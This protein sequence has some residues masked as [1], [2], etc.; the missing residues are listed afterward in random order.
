MEKVES[1]PAIK[2]VNCLL[3]TLFPFYANWMSVS[4]LRR[5][6]ELIDGA[7]DIPPSLQNEY[8][9]IATIDNEP[10]LYQEFSATLER[11]EKLEEKAKSLVSTTTIAVTIAFGISGAVGNLYKFINVYWVRCIYSGLAVASLAYMLFGG[12]SSIRVFT[13]ELQTFF[14]NKPNHK[15]L[16][17]NYQNA[18]ICNNLQ[19]LIRNN[20]ISTAYECIR[21]S[22]VLLFVIATS[23][24][25]V[26]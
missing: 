15:T 13:S 20:Y 7:D 6:I 18:I 19:N 3:N 10:R 5:K 22:L 17:A 24:I 8:P 4:K 23:L 11:K 14:P 2:V 1:S 9:D 21:N 25:M 12:L 26:A 16:V